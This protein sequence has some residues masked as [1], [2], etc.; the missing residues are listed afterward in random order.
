MQWSEELVTTYLGHKI[1][2]IDQRR[3]AN[4]SPTWFA[5]HKGHMRILSDAD[6]ESRLHLYYIIKILLQ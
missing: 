4:M 3:E 1:G 5:T 6:G 2:S